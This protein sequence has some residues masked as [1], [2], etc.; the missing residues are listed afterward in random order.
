[1]YTL[2]YF[3]ERLSQDFELIMHQGRFVSIPARP[4][5]LEI[6]EGCVK[7]YITREIAAKFRPR[8]NSRITNPQQQPTPQEQLAELMNR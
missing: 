1:M 4:S 5:V 2:P 6:L 3:R 8:R 7:Q